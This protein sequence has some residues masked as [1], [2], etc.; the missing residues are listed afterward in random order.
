MR[1]ALII[2]ID[3]YERIKG[4]G[5]CVKDALAVKGVLERHGDGRANF[6][7][8]KMMLCDGP[9]SLISKAELKQ[10]ARELFQQPAEIALIYFAG[11]GYVE[12]TGGYLC[13]SD[14][15]SGDDGLALNDLVL[16]ANTSPAT[17]R[18]IILDSCHSG[19]AGTRGGHKR[20]AE[21]EEGTTILTASTAMQSAMEAYG[22]GGVFT[23]LFVDALNGGAAN[24]V[25]DV[26]P[27]SI[28][29]HIDQSLG[30]NSQRPVFKTNVQSFIS[31]RTVQSPIDYGELMQLATFFPSD[32]FEFPLDPAYEPERNTEQLADPTIPPPDAAKNKIFRILQNLV[33]VNLVV[34]VDA[35][36]MW[37]AAMQSK[38]CQ[39]TVLGKHYR[40]LVESG[41]I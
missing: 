41:M 3:H 22:G 2:G 25:G 37:H 18:I 16:F 9:R 36:H 7:Q 15:E 13:S 31:L 12:D 21:L 26:T 40:K 4:L 8:P 32:D 11:H 23:T 28:Y 6:K 19:A 1:R 24:L 5:G 33:K 38:A 35:P 30:P 34:P 17:N 29:A 20:T 27:G 39:L 14:S 10:A